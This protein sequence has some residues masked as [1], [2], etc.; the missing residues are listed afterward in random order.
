MDVKERS[1]VPE[2]YTWDLSSMYASDEDF[3]AALQAA[4][5]M[6]QR[7]VRFRGHAC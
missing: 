4:Q 5:D 3:L 1:Q 2:R 7:L 6:P